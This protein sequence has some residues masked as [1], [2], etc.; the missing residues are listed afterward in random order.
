[1]T[2]AS[3]KTLL[4]NYLGFLRENGYLYHEGETP[5]WAKLTTSLAPSPKPSAPAQA[6]SRPSAKAPP[7]QT[8]SRPAPHPAPRQEAQP[9]L[10]GAKPT[11]PEHKIM[12]KPESLSRPERIARIDGA[13]ARA[14][15]CRACALGGARNK[16]VYGS[17]DAESKLMFVGEAPG[18]EEDKTGIPFIG[19]AGKLLDQ[20]IG[21]IGF[22]RD[23]VYICNT[24]KCRPP[25]NRDPLPSEK[26][27]CEHF[28]VEQIEI[29]RPAVIV[30]LGAHAAQYLCR[31]DRPIG[32]MRGTWYD[33]HGTP[34]YVTY[35]PAFLLR[36]PGMK[37][38]AWEDFQAVHTRYSELHP[39]DPRKI[40]QKGS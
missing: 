29:I 24:L 17:G 20:M 32:K 23:D 19:R 34:L 18:G 11:L 38:R 39:D 9:S 36:S 21:A 7:V 13:I 16:L 2:E 5:D 6:P 31:S 40:W 26:E 30:A 3:N 22:S 33:Y 4:L 14:E 37:G 8:V 1:M 35:H 12:P 10:F 28:L 15:A 25:G 27:A